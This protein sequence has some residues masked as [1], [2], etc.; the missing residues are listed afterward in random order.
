MW[1]RIT[2]SEQLRDISIGTLLVKYPV[3]GEAPAALDIN[4]RERLSLRYVMKNL[5]ALQEFDLSLIP[6]QIEH[7]LLMVSGL[8]NLSFA[9]M[10]KKYM[11]IVA[12]GNYWIF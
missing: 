3:T 2:S 12:E 5:P 6:Y 1:T 9:A 11:E 8:S 10:H 7:F 4:D